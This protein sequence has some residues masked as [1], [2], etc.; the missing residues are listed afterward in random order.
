LEITLGSRQLDTLVERLEGQAIMPIRSAATVSVFATIA[1]ALL[2]L[3]LPG[4]AA[5]GKP[6]WERVIDDWLANGRITGTYQV[7]CYRQALKHV[8]EDLRDYSNI[9]DAI[10]A[11]LLAQARSNGSPS[12]PGDSGSGAPGAEKPRKLQVAPPRSYYRRAIDNL[13]TTSADSLPIPLLVLASLGGLL[14]LTAAGLAGA[15]RYKTIRGR[16]K[17]PPPAA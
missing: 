6:C 13:G 16:T 10:N 17:P 15:K 5:A 11:G 4:Q 3:A 1:C 8:P 7:H 12:G 9:T 14:L 2:L